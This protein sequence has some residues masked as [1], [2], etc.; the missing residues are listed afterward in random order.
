VAF[1][2]PALLLKGLF[3]KKF[4]ALI[5]ALT[6]LL[7][8][9]ACTTGQGNSEDAP[10][11][12]MGE[13]S[14]TDAQKSVF[15][16][17]ADE[18]VMSE[19][20][21]VFDAKKAQTEGFY[22]LPEI[23]GTTY[24]ISSK[25]GNDSANGKSPST[26]WKSCSK[27]NSV[28]FKSGDAVLFECGSEFRE[29]V[30]LKSGV[31]YASY[32]D[33][34][35]PLF[36]GSINASK[37]TDWVAVSGVKNLYQYNATLSNSYDIG[38][39]VF[40]GGEAWGIKI[41]QLTDAKKS[42]ELRDVSNGIEYFDVIKSFDLV[43]GKDLKNGKYDLSY[44]HD[45]TKLYLYC[46]DGNPAERFDSIELS[47]ANQ[48]AGTFS[49]SNVSDVTIANISFKNIGRFAIRTTA[50]KNLAVYNCEFDFIG[51][52]VQSDNQD[53]GRNHKT[54]LGNAIENWNSCDGM[55]VENCYFNQ[56]YD[57]AMTT[58]S[59]TD[60]T[61]MINI[62]YK[63]NVV[64]NVVYAIELWSSGAENASCNFHN[65]NV[66]GNVCRNIGYGFTTQR[67]DKVTGFL[68]AY[69]S[70]YQYQNAY[71]KDNYVIGTLDWIYRTNNI[72]T[73][74]SPNGYELD[75]NVYVNTLG[76]DI[77]MLSSSFPKYSKTISEYEYNYSTIKKLYDAGIDKNGKFY[78]VAEEGDENA[79]YNEMLNAYLL[80]NPSYTYKLEGGEELQFRLLLPK[81]YDAE[82]QYKLFT[83]FNYEYA[84][85]TDNFKNVQMSNRLIGELYSS[86]E[87]I[88]LVP[89]CPKDSWIGVDIKNGNYSTKDTAES[90]VMKSVYG[91]IND[92]SI[93]YGTEKTF[94]AG[95][96]S[97]GYAVADIIARHENF[98]SAALIIS[99]AGDVSATVG[100]TKVWIIHGAGDE[101]V[102]VDNAKALKD[103][104]GAKYTELDRE[105]HD[106]WNTAFAREDI[107]GW[108]AQQ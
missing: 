12:K 30:Y 52:S 56:I 38:S 99:G 59:N 2:T 7:S 16:Q 60:G 85:G 27:L 107:L 97:G 37:T 70:Y 71:V 98:I 47:K 39:I 68:S 86:G 19:L 46:K 29:S 100:S 95:V 75:G 53:F 23:T 15:W 102:S 18:G 49:A 20:N 21:A 72:K 81:D 51:G 10:K 77:G 90:G 108:F 34:E 6:C 105:L 40:N 91:L 82:K 65:V 69:G 25:N 101:K 9:F 92:I 88:I 32:G 78:F 13:I 55:I 96:S 43:S 76:N 4:L 84:S 83:Y 61:D 74:D 44:Y 50:V 73:N 1:A 33:G 31:T 62:S 3:M 22:K 103:A 63:N 87:Y 41:Q 67:P 104:W 8:L 24:Y 26:A 94:A 79:L 35:K 36:L 5:L 80:S 28:T 89:Q 45:T 11:E 17:Y 14:K 57:T 106:C 48:N 64:E 66:E 58:Q 42:L 93:E 54:R